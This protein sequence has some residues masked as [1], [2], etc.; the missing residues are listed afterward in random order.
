MKDFP[1]KWED[2]YTFKE[3]K[4][5]LEQLKYLYKGTEQY[6]IKIEYLKEKEKTIVQDIKKLK[7]FKVTEKE[8]NSKKDYYSD[9]YDYFVEINDLIGK[10]K[11]EKLYKQP[12]SKLV[13]DFKCEGSFPE[14]WDDLFLNVYKDIYKL[15]HLIEANKVRELYKNLDKT[16]LSEIKWWNYDKYK[17][18]YDNSYSQRLKEIKKMIR[19]IEEKGYLIYDSYDNYER[20]KII[21][22]YMFLRYNYDSDI[23]KDV[24][25]EYENEFINMTDK[26]NQ[27]ISE[28]ERKEREKR[29][30][31]EREEEEKR[32]KEREEEEN[33]DEDDSDDNNSDSNDNNNYNSYNYYSSS[34]KYSS[35]SSKNNSSS[36]SSNKNICT[37]L[38]KKYLQV[39]SDCKNKCVGCRKKLKSGDGIPMG[40]GLH[41]KCFK[42]SC[43]FC[44]KNNS[45]VSERKTSYCCKSCRQSNKYDQ[46]KCLAC[47]KQ[48]K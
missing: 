26:I 44:G 7:H 33:N 23:D 37:D 40:F 10:A 38:K 1:E 47:H 3:T 41:E 18:N 2:L 16:I 9:N 29:E 11:K 25:E 28:K 48:F 43:Y 31:E 8:I 15:K 22:N 39:C 34:K 27:K 32:R 46:T 17:K 14:K 21:Q 36:G 13:S 6:Y 12:L 19:L 4:E 45:S 35:S 24:L 5:Q 42:S 30:K 20:D